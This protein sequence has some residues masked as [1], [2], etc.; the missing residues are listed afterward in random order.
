MYFKRIVILVYLTSMYTTMNE[1]INAF[2][3][4]TAFD[5]IRVR[6]ITQCMFW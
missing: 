3:T 4:L 1:I 5:I 6:K 2:V